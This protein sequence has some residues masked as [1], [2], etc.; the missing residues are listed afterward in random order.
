LE[1]SVVV[2]ANLAAGLVIL[3]VA[4]ALALPLPPGIQIVAVVIQGL[5]QGLSASASHVFMLQCLRR[6]TTPEGLAQALKRAFSIT[7]VFAVAG[8]LGAQYLLRPGLSFLPYPYD[9]V[10]IHLIAALCAFGIARTAARFRLAPLTDEPRQAFFPF[11]ETAFRGFGGNPELLALW[12]AYLLWYTSLGITSNLALYT[13][14]AMGRDPKDYSGLIMAI[15]LGS[16]SIGGYGLGVLEVRRGLRTGVLA[17]IALL[18]AGGAWAWLVPGAG[19]LFS[20]GLLG[21]GEL[22]GAYLPNYVGLL[23]PATQAARNLPLL[24][25]ATPAS[26]FSPVLYGARTDRY[27]FRA[28]FAFGILTAAAALILVMC[29]RAAGVNHAA[30]LDK[31]SV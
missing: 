30:N 20:F 10:A 31:N 1:R 22:G 19:Y 8:S 28:S 11:L 25:L 9:F 18:A 4:V 7:P 6:G 21:A 2:W 16:K 3:L 15:R 23:S 12:F 14:E 13:R 27:G 24:T 26:S 29:V 17:A 5:L